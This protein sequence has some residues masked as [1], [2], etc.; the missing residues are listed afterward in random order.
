MDVC[1]LLQEQ[2][3]QTGKDMYTTL[4]YLNNKH[5]FLPFPGQGK[6]SS[7]DKDTLKPD[8]STTFEATKSNMANMIIA[9]TKKLEEL[10]MTLPGLQ[11]T[12]HEQV[13]RITELQQ[14]LSSIEER[15]AQAITKRDSTHRE[16]EQLI[17]KSASAIQAT[18]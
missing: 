4:E 18:R 17:T 8:D 5:D 1:S 10:V 14:Q 2:I 16:L 15:R 3:D 7:N 12:E 13:A 9:D 6:V 11:R